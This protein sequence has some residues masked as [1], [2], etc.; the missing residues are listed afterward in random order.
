MYFGIIA[1]AIYNHYLLRPSKGAH[2]RTNPIMSGAVRCQ[3][4]SILI[5][6]PGSLFGNEFLCYEDAPTRVQSAR[7]SLGA[8]RD[9]IEPDLSPKS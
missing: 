8:K 4:E 5:S 7:S 9:S 3:M 1:R 6:S 2:L